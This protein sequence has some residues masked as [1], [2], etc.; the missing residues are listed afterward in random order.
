MP[1]NLPA[2]SQ[3]AE[4]VDKLGSCGT[5]ITSTS[6]AEPA[7]G[8]PIVVLETTFLPKSDT[9]RQPCG[10]PIAKKC[11]VYVVFLWR[12][13]HVGPGVI[14]GTAGGLRW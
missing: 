10:L 5:K 9:A 2:K 3:A 12:S 4:A 1:A 14:R 8:F 13:S 7:F 6:R 11:G